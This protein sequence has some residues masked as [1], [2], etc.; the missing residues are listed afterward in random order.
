MMLCGE[1]PIEGGKETSRKESGEVESNIGNSTENLERSPSFDGYKPASEQYHGFRFSQEEVR[2]SYGME[3]QNLVE[4]VHKRAESNHRLAKEN[5]EQPRKSKKLKTIDPLTDK[6]SERPWS[7]NYNGK[8]LSGIFEPLSG[9]VYMGRNFTKGEIRMRKWENFY[10][11]AEP[12]IQKRIHQLLNNIS[13]KD[14]EKY[15][16]QFSRAQIPGQHSEVIALDKALKARRQI[17]KRKMTEKDIEELL[18][19]N[20]NMTD[21]SKVPPRCINCWFITQGIKVIGND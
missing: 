5:Q 16:Y 2:N 21:P 15:E 11:N 7:Q 13:K 14:R 8:V 10:H 3:G 4:E 12:I 17:L 9:K 18:L 1:N 19:H 6:M 20:R